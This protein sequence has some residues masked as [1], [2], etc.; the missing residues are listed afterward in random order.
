MSQ[1]AYLEAVK[2]KLQTILNLSAESCD[3]MLTGEPKP[4]AGEWFVAIHPGSWDGVSMDADFS[5]TV[6]FQ[7]TVSLKLGFS[8]Q[9]KFGVE[10]WKNLFEPLVRKIATGLH[11]NNVLMQV[12]NNLITTGDDKFHQPVSFQGASPPEMKNQ[13][14]WQSYS[15]TQTHV[16]YAGMAQTLNFGGANRVQDLSVME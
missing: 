7:V 14:W 4:T 13:E 8:P 6:G 11:Q 2:R 5:E 10:A 16:A 15:Q 12:A 9:T 3:I 1:A